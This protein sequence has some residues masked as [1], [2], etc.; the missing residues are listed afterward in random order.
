MLLNYGAKNFSCFKEG[1]EI[2]FE[3]GEKAANLLCV[4]GKNGAGKTNALKII[5]F[6]K[7]FC[8]DSF[9]Y[10]PED[11]IYVDAHFYSRDPV[12]LFCEM[13]I[14]SI[15]YRYEVSLTEEQVFSEVLIRKKNRSTEIFRREG[16]ELINN[17]KEFDDLKKIKLRS[18]ASIISTAHQYESQ[19]LEP[20]YEFFETI[21]TN[22]YWGGRRDNIWDFEQLSKIYYDNPKVLKYTKAIIKKCDLGIIDINIWEKIDEKGKKEYHPFFKHDSTAK[23][24]ELGFD[25]QSSGTKALYMTLPSYFYVISLSGTLVLDEF[26]I[27]FH[28]DIL[29]QLIELIENNNN[30][31]SNSAQLIFTT[32]NSDIMD[33]M[34]KYR[35]ILIDQ[36]NSESYGYRLDEIPGDILR[37]DRPITPVYKSGK[38]GGV[39][40]V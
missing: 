26:D 7:G 15:R 6:L 20:I 21:L 35:T 10:K 13:K 1:I 16:N 31:N 40:R 38:I 12:D 17:I 3:K 18:N 23:D 25:Y 34:G 4:K 32:H 37:N 11:P 27:N 28:P 22:V 39:P 36:K 5:S 30:N 33:K 29:P 9:D 8:R 2:S 19:S 14:N 24:N